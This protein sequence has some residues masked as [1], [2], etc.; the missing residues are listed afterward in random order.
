MKSG[1][2]I[3]M[4]PFIIV[5]V[6]LAHSDI[7]ALSMAYQYYPK[8]FQLT[9]LLE[10][11]YQYTESSGGS[12]SDTITLKRSDLTQRYTFG[13]SGYVYDPRLLVFSSRVSYRHGAT[14][15]EGEGEGT[16]D[17]VNYNLSTTFL[18]YRPISLALYANKTD[19]TVDGTYLPQFTMTS[20]SHGASV[21]IKM[22]NLPLTSLDYTHWQYD[23][24]LQTGVIERDAYTLRV[25]GNVNPI[26]LRMRYI[27]NAE[28]SNYKSPDKEYT[29]KQI[30]LYQ[31]TSIKKGITL[32]TDLYYSSREDYDLYNLDIGLEVN[33]LNRLRHDYTYEF[34][35][36]STDLTESDT[37]RLRASLGYKFNQYLT[38]R[39]SLSAGL[40]GVEKG[41]GKEDGSSHGIG[42]G[43]TYTRKVSWFDTR[44]YWRGSYSHREGDELANQLNGDIIL[45]N[46]GTDIVMRRLSYATIHTGYDFSDY[47]TDEGELM[48][49]HTRLG[50]SGRGPKR[51][52]WRLE[53]SYRVSE[54]DETTSDEDGIARIQEGTSYS[55]RAEA[56]YPIS[57]RGMVNLNTGYEVTETNLDKWDTI[58]YG[59]RANYL[60]TRNL[61]SSGWWA[62][63]WSNDSERITM[64]G[65]LSL[66]YRLRKTYLTAEYSFR[67]IE[68]VSE[69]SETQSIL[70]K[71]TRVIW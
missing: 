47:K 33:P 50:I 52:Y 20:L 71:L 69:S 19:S 45:N 15:T 29:S 16:M 24:E 68:E 62:H 4:L 14:S 42:G 17:S 25:W 34:N 27:I 40:T 66:R 60:I 32:K 67:E 61:F 54:G 53:G 18:P 10:L 56:G 48:T 65:T 9:G 23:S 49:H 26:K 2:L 7:Y 30:W 1:Y 51:V 31:D 8:R 39:L 38:G 5:I 70:L 28:V 46:V 11:T 35:H 44:T 6:F 3:F 36:T 12:D 22:K 58:Y 55:V 57:Y 41:E 21:R 64:N 13:L 59:I 63:S 37:H 43:L